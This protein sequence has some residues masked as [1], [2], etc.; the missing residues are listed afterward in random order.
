MKGHIQQRGKDTWRVI[1]D[2]PPG[3]Q[4]QRRQ[5]S[6]TV[7][8]AK[9]DAQAKLRKV[10]TSLDHGDYMEPTNETVG[11][12]LDRWMETYAQSNTSLRTQ[13]DYWGIIRRY[14]R[15]VLGSVQLAALRPDHILALH[16]QLYDRG[17]SSRTVLHVYRVLSEAMSHAVKWRLVGRNICAAVD[18]PRAERKEMVALDREGITRF[19]D[20]ANESPYRDVYFL[21]LY[22]GLRRSEA[23]AL[24]WPQVD[25]ERGYVSVVEGLHRLPG[26]GLVLLSVKTAKSR[27]RVAISQEVIDLLHGIRGQQM[28][29]QVS[30]G[31]GWQDSGFVFT[32]SDGRPFDPEK[33]SKGFATIRK[34][35][36]LPHVRLHD[37]RHAHAS[38]MLQAGENPK[39][40]S[41]RLG[42]ASVQITMDVY[43]HVLPGAHEQAAERFSKLLGDL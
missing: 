42:H 11:S 16:A 22:T 32:R 34:A 28:A 30:A 1:Y 9:R 38:L 23:L 20:A 17:L 15:P 4:G 35:A 8:G 7:H 2:A 25:L 13:R 10:L 14:L 21:A 33:V 3:P 12:F 26:R 6:V 41:E 43:A 31:S 39:V 36:G 18:P 40:V 19:F 24:K 29:Q 5:R 37:L 27:R